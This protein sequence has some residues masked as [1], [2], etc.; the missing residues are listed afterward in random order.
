M[1][2]LGYGWPETTAVQLYTVHNIFPF[3]SDEIVRRGAAHQGLTWHYNRP[4]VVDLDY[5]MDCR[6]VLQE[7]IV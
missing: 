3:L 1:A 6:C 5:E 2:A 4:P 7:T